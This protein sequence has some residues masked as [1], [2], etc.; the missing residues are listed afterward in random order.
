MAGRGFIYVAANDVGLVK[1]GITDNYTIRIGALRRSYGP[2]DFEA[3]FFFKDDSIAPNLERVVKEKY[4]HLACL[5]ATELFKIGLQEV[6]TTIE[7]SIYE[8]GFSTKKTEF[9][10]V[11]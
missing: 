9:V 1:V 2:M 6:I 7:K 10:R 3:I 5:P 4:K 11:L 8:Q